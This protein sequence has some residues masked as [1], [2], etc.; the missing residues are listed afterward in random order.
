VNK[1]NKE[2]IN[3]YWTTESTQNQEIDW[4]FL[5]PKP[6]NLF[7]ELIEERNNPK[8]RMSYFLCPAVS[9]KFKKTLTFNNSINCSYEFGKKEKEFYIKPTSKEF[10][11]AELVREPAI[12]KG[13]TFLFSL[14]Y[15][16]FAD[17]SL[18]VSFTAPYFHKPKY[19]KNGTVMPGEF[20]I[21][22]WFRPYGFEV[23]MWQEDG[24]FH[25]EDGEPLFYAE[26]KT[27]RPILF[28]RFLMTPQLQKYK[29]A[30]TKSFEVLG[31]FQ[32][33]QEKYEKFKQVGFKE[34][35]LNEIKKNVIEEK[36]YKF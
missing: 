9:T 31:P 34:K 22:K 12:T 14:N 35:I 30:N 24:V 11:H 27:D 20:N 7:S 26:F 5:Y 19:F 16:F 21:G 18:D 29:Q 2:P 23:Q 32:T 6:K 8:D 13:P 25:I 36:P 17:D 33:L 28:H 10:I 1:K 15:L 3:V 4:S